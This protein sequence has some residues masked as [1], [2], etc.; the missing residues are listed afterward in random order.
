MRRALPIL[1]VALFLAPSTAVPAAAAHCD[2]DRWS[3][4]VACRIELALHGGGSLR[5]DTLRLPR[6]ETVELHVAP[7]D[8]DGQEFPWDRFRFELDL[9]RECDD[10]LEAIETSDDGVT[11]RTGRS[12]GTCG[13]LLWIPGNLNLDRELRI[14]V[15]ASRPVPREELDEIV[16]TREE[17]VAVSLFRAVLVRDPDRRWLEEA[18]EGVRRG[19]TRELIA[20]LVASPEFSQRRRSEPP[21]VLLRDFYEGLLGRD[22][23]PSG[24]RTYLGDVRDGDY[25]DVL[26]SI[27]R[28]EEFALRV[29]REIP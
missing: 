12:A 21:E 22:P 18:A 7:Y 8:Q 20:S 11:L 26:L 24:F 23:D 2:L 19:S 14:E 16:D 27:L 1:A 4:P 6:S 13:A 5:G 17:L 15:G 29:S 25:T 9:D 10:L 28:S 3:E